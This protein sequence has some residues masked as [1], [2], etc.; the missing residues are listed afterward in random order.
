MED[1]DFVFAKRLKEERQALELSQDDVARK[2]G[3]K[4]STYAHYETGVAFPDLR[5][6]ATLA[7]LLDVSADYLLGNTD[8]KT[9]PTFV[10]GTARLVNISREQAEK[11]IASYLQADDHTRQ[12]IDLL[13]RSK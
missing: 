10:D 9:R 2:L 4:R 1:R 6:L 12:A 13:I 7:T 8:I 3:I 11:L 5:R